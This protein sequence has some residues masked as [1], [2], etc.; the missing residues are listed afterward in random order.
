MVRRWIDRGWALWAYLALNVPLVLGVILTSAAPTS[1]FRS[2]IAALSIVALGVGMYWQRPA[3]PAAWWLLGAGAVA[4]ALATWAGAAALFTGTGNQPGDWYAPELY[5][6]SYVLFIAGLA[7]LAQLSGRAYVTD[8][9]DAMLVAIATFLL[10]YWLVIDAILPLDRTG[11]LAA[12]VYPL[13]ALMLFAMTVRAALS[14]GVPTVSVG[15]LLLSMVARVASAVS[16]LEPALTTGSVERSSLT[17]YLNTT[18]S[19]LL[20][21]SALHPSLTAIRARIERR[22]DPVSGLRMALFALLAVVALTVL[23]GEIWMLAAGAGTTNLTVALAAASMLLILLASRLGLTARVAQRWAAELT[24]RSDDL[25]S[26]VKEQ[27][28]LQRQLRHQAM[29]DPLTGL[30]N[31]IVLSERLEWVLTRPS[32]SGWHALAIIDLDWFRQ[33]NETL[34]H[35]VGDALLVDVS[36][37]LLAVTP[38]R[39]MLVRLVGD[40][41]VVLLEDTRPVEA[42]HWAEQVQAELRKP[43]LVGD[44]EVF[45]TVSIGLLFTEAAGPMTTAAQAL[46][47][48]DLALRAAKESGRNRVEVFRPELRTAQM[49]LTRLSNG[50]R[51][52]LTRDE[53]ALVYQPVVNLT[54]GHVAAVEALLRWNPP[55]LSTSPSEFIPVAEE[56]GMIR[57]IGAWVLRTACHQARPW[58]DRHGVAVAVNVSARQLDDPG[59]ADL[60][61]EVL[62]GTGLPGSALILEITESSLVASTA[63]DGT[64]RQL[65]KIRSFGVRVAI[66]DFG[67]GYSSLSYLSHLP[68]D[69]VKIDSSFVQQPNGPGH[70]AQRWAFTRAILHLVEAMQLQAVA[71]GVETR[72]QAAALRELRC[73]FAQGYLLGGPTPPGAVER[74]LSDAEEREALVLP[75]AGGQAAGH[76]RTA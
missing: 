68:V 8:M 20:G 40:E 69:I 51:T 46:R 29:H 73:P 23:A 34:G 53:L 4:S 70:G 39:G 13:G 74:M 37:R 32:E 36:H 3:V 76:R 60:V 49:Y 57:P 75:V 42:R 38:R 11:V 66:D 45:I 67:T 44:H 2:V 47:D 19:I 24:Q 41:F 9:L 65:E 31:R 6:L 26:A 43:Y 50:L 16:M 15:L 62:R 14:V 72:V 71:E 59:F 48:V 5:A 28:V 21:A 58:Y 33:V 12:V 61:L 18:A 54:T 22:H 63:I 25:A 30:P 52:A 1:A 10:L 64:M 56:T 7:L 17:P 55:G 27:E 35:P